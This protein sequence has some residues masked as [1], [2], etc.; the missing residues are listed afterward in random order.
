MTTAEAPPAAVLIRLLPATAA[1]A[2]VLAPLLDAGER[3]RAALFR[4]DEN[5][6][7]YI[8]AH[9][10]LRRSLSEAAPQTA[11]ADWRFDRDGRGKPF[12]R[13]P[14]PT[15]PFSLTHCRG[16]AACAVFRPDARPPAAH[17][18]AAHNPD[19]HDPASGDVVGIDAESL[20][21]R[22][23]P[24]P[25]AQRFF[26]PAEAAALAALSDVEERRRA[27]LRLW[28]LKEAFVKATGTGIADSL[29]SFSFTL[30]DPPRLT[31]TD[32]ETAPPR[33]WRIE[34]RDAAVETGVFSVA[35]ALRRDSAPERDAGL[36]IDF[37]ISEPTP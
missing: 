16:L 34:R 1:A 20:D 9:G 24:L 17:N 36:H 22:L 31:T 6:V 32:A 13:P 25:L 8:C 11:A 23:S 21:R 18:S 4:N 35:L 26:A 3:E 14:G 15:P 19:A 12:V 10:L 28:T 37:Q 27:F 5:R 2:A 7:A 29:Q 33:R 30:D